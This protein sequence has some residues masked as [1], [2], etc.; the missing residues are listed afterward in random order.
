MRFTLDSP[1]SANLVT[2]VGPDG[3]RIGELLLTR[4]LIVSATE[5]LQDW[6]ARE[7]ETLDLEILAPALALDPEI[8]LLGTGPR[9]RFPGSE[10]YAALAARGIGLEVMDT[11][12]A[13]RTFNILVHEERPVVAAL[14]LP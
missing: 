6:P 12:A 10:L 8:L 13:C 9:L 5:L 1:P 2:G 3:I 11:P 4:S 14:L 7:I